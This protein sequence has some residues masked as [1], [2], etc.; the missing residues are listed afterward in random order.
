MASLTRTPS[1]WPTIPQVY[2]KG[3]FIGGCDIMLEMLRS[4]ELVKMLE[5]AGLRKPM[6]TDVEK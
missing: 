6:P 1:N 5:D 2:L 3:E 4:G